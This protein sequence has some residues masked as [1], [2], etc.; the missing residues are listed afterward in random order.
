MTT[1]IELTG[2]KRV[3]TW[4]EP[5]GNGHDDVYQRETYNYD[6]K[7]ELLTVSKRNQGATDVWVETSN[8]DYLLAETIRA[9]VDGR[10]ELTGERSIS[11]CCTSGHND[12]RDTIMGDVYRVVSI[13]GHGSYASLL[14]P[15]V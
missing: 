2:W 4:Q 12:W 1:T 15:K 7:V 10:Y 14:S 9:N 5:H 8:H 11:P 13:A 6:G 3:H